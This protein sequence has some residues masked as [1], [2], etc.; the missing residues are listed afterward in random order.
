MF[1]T[2]PLKKIVN[3]KIVYLAVPTD[4]DFGLDKICILKEH[5]IKAN[6]KVVLNDIEY[7]FCWTNQ[8]D[9]VQCENQEVA[10][11][12]NQY[13][14][15]H[16]IGFTYWGDNH[17]FFKL[18]FS[19]GT[20]ECAKIFFPDWGHPMENINNGLGSESA[21]RAKCRLADVFISSGRGK[22]LLNI[23]QFSYKIE[24]KKQ[25][26]KIMFPDNIMTHIFAITLES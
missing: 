6:K 22:V 9:N 2:I 26:T 21:T 5:F 13:N 16:F 20:H 15:I 4:S 11:S 19:D 18:I 1:T 14:E 23:Y 10:V 7:K 8:F 17:I 24:S 25:L 3:H 12:K